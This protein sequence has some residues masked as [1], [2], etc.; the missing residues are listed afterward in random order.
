M[1]KALNYF[2]GALAVLVLGWSAAGAEQYT[3][4]LFP[5]PGTSG[6]LQ[7]VL[8]IVNDTGETATVQVFAFADD[9]TRSGPAT[10]ALGA[11]AAVQF[12][13]TEL[14]SSNA[15][16]GLSGGLGSLSGDVRLS[17]D[18]DTPIVPQAFVR[19]SD[20]TL[21]AMHD[22]V[23]PAR[24]A[25][26]MYR[27]EIPVFNLS[28]D[29][30]QESRLR[31]I[32]PGTT[33]A[34]VTIAGRDDSGTGAGGGDMTLSLPAGS[35][36]TLTAEQLEAGGTG[37][38]GT[39]GAGIGRWRLT[40]SSDRPLRVVN[41]G[42]SYTGHWNN[43]STTAVRGAAPADLAGF[44]ERFVGQTSVLEVE[45]GRNSF[46]IRGNGRF[47]ETMQTDAM[48]AT[49]EGG[50]D[51]VGLGPD[52]GRLT[53]DYDNG[54][55]CR[56]NLYFSSRTRGWFSSHCTD[57]S[58][59]GGNWFVGEAED[60]GGDGGPVETTFGVDMALP[61]VPTSGLFDPAEV[62]GGNVRTSGGSTTIDLN[63]G[64]YIEL[65]DGVRY[66]CV[67]A[68]GCE[69][70]D[71]TV[72]RGSMTGRAPGSG[73]GGIDRIPVL[74]AQG[75]PGDRT[76]TVGTTIDAL[77]L[78]QA[79]GGDL[80][81]T[82]SLSPDVPGLRFDAA[83]R[84]LS[85]TP[86][87]AGSY[88]MSYTA[89]DADGDQY[90]FHF[91]IAVRG[92]AAT[93]IA[94]SFDVRPNS[95]G[96]AYAGELFYALSWG[97]DKVYAYTGTGQRDPDNDFDLVDDAGPLHRLAY[98]N[99]R[100]Y[101]FHVHG[102]GGK[103][104]AYTVTGQRDASNDFILHDDNVWPRGFAS[105]A[106]RNYVVNVRGGKVYAYTASGTRE[107]AA[108]FDLDDDNRSPSG[109]VYAAGRFYV[110]DSQADKV[111]AYT[112]SGG[113]NAGADFE[114][115][116]DNGD[117]IGIAYANGSFHVLNFIDGRIYRYPG[118]GGQTNLSVCF[119]A[120]SDP[121]TQIFRVG[122]AT[123]WTLPVARPA[124]RGSG[125]L[126]YSL[127]PAIPG[128]AFNAATRRL[129]G[130]PTEAG[131]FNMTYTVTDA[132]GESDSLTFVIAV[133]SDP[134]LV[135]ES[136]SV[137][138]SN[139]DEGDSLTFRVTVH[140]RGTSQSEATTLRYY[141]S[142]NAT[143]ST[144]DTLVGM[145]AVGALDASASSTESI[146]LTAPSSDGTYYY[147]ACVDRV[148]DESDT[149]NN[150]SIGVLVT[151]GES[152]GGGGGTGA[153]RA[154]LVVNPGESCTYKGADFRVSS[155]GQGSMLVGGIFVASSN[156]IDQRGATVNGVR[157]NFYATRNSGSNSWTIEVAD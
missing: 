23:R 126:T 22:T 58:R 30:T 131:R 76:Y 71:G 118:T 37:L 73:G 117:A 9:G 3:I 97:D 138:D 34:A 149:R 100:F 153:C 150:C 98:A 121:G 157:W 111:F 60:D 85:G 106:G 26:G 47:S 18:S 129:S 75:R 52:A 135:V 128:L 4:P 42:A 14:Q 132:G 35:A 8:R 99:G 80:P 6:D 64:G 27:Y 136:P 152:G 112:G 151:V 82:Y 143:I 15:A 11:M 104:F 40:V 67:S 49:S 57:G 123:N 32:N 2:T 50:Y 90:S 127:S 148:P 109:I 25:G 91:T 1:L 120:S 65:N 124:S 13:A 156:Q 114:L 7:G 46:E 119:P 146:S 88:A 93:G 81:L 24:T 78:P 70:V 145:D 113:R 29:A 134:D 122:T 79:T 43:L 87:E 77:T 141:R 41:V 116:C 140:N 56:A 10:I 155:S 130:T 53:L 48:F 110:V 137:S 66:A 21:S 94:G 12:D 59:Y 103:L 38:T 19:A 63:D 74:P 5:A 144:S 28:T 84:R 96:I 68:G 44:N 147:G 108:D 39:L 102:D 115:A 83:A 139:P 61:G 107:T 17:I 125:P 54:S 92:E 33:A 95:R 45:G 51:Y 31:L 154:G 55:R 133:L 105:V 86:T 36:R 101:V 69:I 62:S 142:T 16:R 72:T 89:T 20:G